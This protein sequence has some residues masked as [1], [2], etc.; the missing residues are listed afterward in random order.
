[1]PLVIVP[2]MA[3]LVLGSCSKK[4]PSLNLLV[5]EGYADPQFTKSF[6]DKYGVKVSGTYFGSS[7]EW[8]IGQKL[9]WGA[10]SMPHQSADDKTN[11]L[12]VCAS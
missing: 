11:Y 4:T 10:V 8:D 6:E 12:P 2:L 5:W 9:G 7:D 3:V 1:M